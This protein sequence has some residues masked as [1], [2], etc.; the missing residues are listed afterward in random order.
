MNRGYVKICITCKNTNLFIKH[1][2]INK[3][4]YDNF[5]QIN[6]RKITFKISYEDYLS[7]KEKKGIYKI[8]VIKYYG[9]INFV[10]FVKQN[11][12]F[13]ICFLISII[14]LYFISN[15]CFSLEI[16]HNDSKIRTLVKENLNS[17]N[18]KELYFIPDFMKRKN[19][20]SKIVETNKDKIEWLEI[21]RIGSKL[22][23]KV[24]ERK[25]NKKEEMVENRHIIAKKSGI[26]KNI[27]ASSGVILKKKDDYVTKGDIIVS[28]DIIKDDTVKGQVISRGKVYAETW[29][30][31]N[32]EY[33]LYYEE[34]K[35]LPEVKNNIIIH[36][37]DNDI[38]LKKNYTKSYLEK[39]NVLIKDKIFP[40]S[41]SLEKQR[42]TK[43][44]KQILTYEAATSKALKIAENKIKSFLDDDEYIISKKTL[45]FKSNNSKIKV[46][47]FFKVYENITDY[48]N[49]DKNSLIEEENIE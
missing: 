49:V 48:K 22:L 1:Y 29:Y 34:I 14:V 23:V 12:S 35:Y 17:Y 18:I 3:I 21:E 19:I 40:F 13:L 41:I 47:V 10:L 6:H 25:I 20:I 7:L 8:D 32:V 26:I 42:K 4:K 39:K 5:K 36:F 9:L 28:G 31:V 33:P 43:V 30:N 24:T 45:N 2:L 38:S 16:V 15:I 44:T 27:E 37:F 11:L 46:D